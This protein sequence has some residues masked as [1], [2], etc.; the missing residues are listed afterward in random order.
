[1]KTIRSAPDLAWNQ[2][3]REITLTAKQ[4]LSESRGFLWKVENKGNTVYLLGS[5]HYVLEGMYP[6]RREIEKAFQ[7]ADYLGVELE[8][9]IRWATRG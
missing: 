4:Q 5:I 3:L 9:C 1:M 6:L 2:S 7:A 8:C